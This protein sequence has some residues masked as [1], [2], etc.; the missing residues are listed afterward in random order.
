M[1][2]TLDQ[3]SSMLGTHFA[4]ADS[5]QGLR[6]GGHAWAWTSRGSSAGLTRGAIPAPRNRARGQEP[7]RESGARGTS[8]VG[9]GLVLALPGSAVDAAL[10][11]GHI[12]FDEGVH[13]RLRVV[14]AARSRR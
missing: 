13:R 12:M 10:S 4:F 2:V 3:R 8:P 5:G 11:Q 7:E 9:R 6:S 14:A 1:A